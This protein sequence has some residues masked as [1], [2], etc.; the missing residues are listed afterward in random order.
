VV[1]N[2]AADRCPSCGTELGEIVRVRYEGRLTRVH[3]LDLTGPGG[4]EDPV[5]LDH[6]CGDV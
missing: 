1:S 6:V 5:E 2:A 4:D 3:F